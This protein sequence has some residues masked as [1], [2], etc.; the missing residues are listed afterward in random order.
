MRPLQRPNTFLVNALPFFL[1]SSVLLAPK[2]A[3]AGV[4]S[5]VVTGNVRW[6]QA[7]SPVRVSGEVTIAPGASLTIAPGV[8]VL[9]A[10]APGNRSRGE[11]HGYGITVHG[12]LRAEGAPD[13]L[14]VFR[15]EDPDP[16]APSG[17]KQGMPYDRLRGWNQFRGI[18]FAADATPGDE[19]GKAGCL[20][21]FCRFV[22]A[23]SPV[24]GK[25]TYVDVSHCHFVKSGAGGDRGIAVQLERGRCEYSFFE[26]SG[27]AA[28]HLGGD[29]VAE[30]CAVRGGFGDGLQGEDGAE[31]DNCLVRDVRG[32][33]VSPVGG[34]FDIYYS[35]FE[36]CGSGF[37]VTRRKPQ[38]RVHFE[39]CDFIN[40]GDGIHRGAFTIEEGARVAPGTINLEGVENR[41]LCAVAVVD[42]AG[43]NHFRFPHVW[44]GGKPVRHQE[45]PGSGGS[46]FLVEPALTQDPH[47]VCLEHVGRVVDPAGKPVPNALVYAIFS[48]APVT[49]T[50]AR[51]RYRL[52]GAQPAMYDLYA[53]APGVGL[54][55]QRADWGYAGERLQNVVVLG[56]RNYNP[57][58]E[59]LKP[60][61]RR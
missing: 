39:N 1:I 29:A 50:D 36:S 55:A 57:H 20:V 26:W 4:V 34:E 7:Q 11:P 27:E 12:T 58:S 47:T 25:N 51:G 16:A 23:F 48:M 59:H 60:P 35:R 43:G 21:K 38:A 19:D 32:Y 9:F 3:Q 10:T 5:G 42:R 14:I 18:T 40:L 56:K 46:S 8:V 15:G 17:W 54:G 53:Y 41:V 6:T 30:F 33:A 31:F 24:V 52:E 49:L 28:L 45:A 44:W 2:S 61:V 22:G 37:G 13:D